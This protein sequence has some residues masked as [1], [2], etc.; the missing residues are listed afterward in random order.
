MDAWLRI[1]EVEETTR[2]S[3]EEYARVHLYPAF[4]DAPVGKVSA[5]QLEEFYADLRRCVARCD[6]RPAIEHRS[7][8]PHECRVVKHRRPPGPSAGRWLPAARLRRGW[9]SG[10]RMCAARVPAPL[11][12][13]DP[14]HPLRHPGR[15]L[16]RCALG[17][18]HDEPD[19]RGPE[20]PEADTAARTAQ[21]RASGPDH[22]R[23]MGPGR[24]L[25]AR[26]FGS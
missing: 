22:R 6:G 10:R 21:R 24:R 14:A 2:A 5:R 20:A 26:W 7:N 1:H 12:R 13:G 11:G 23:G 25:G 9:L 16:G 18:D 19:G 17:V 3:Y 4:G 15:P 8:G